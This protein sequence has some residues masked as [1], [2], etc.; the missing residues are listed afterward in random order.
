MPR[1]T[2]LSP[3]QARPTARALLT[4]I[5][6]RHGDAGPM[7]RSMA[8]SPALLQGYLD[9]SRAMKR[10]SLPRP[11]S[12]KISLAVQEW[13]GCALCLAAHTAA[14]RAHGLTESDIVLARQGTAGDVRDAALI[15]FAMQV[16]TEPAMVTDDDITALRAHGWSDRALADVVG[17]VALNQLTGAF[18]LV[19]GLEV[20]DHDAVH[21]AD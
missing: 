5:V 21:A 4:E 13:L 11:L 7:V 18:N 15:T 20:G 9:L 1:L 8:H 3:E 6:E 19:A 14:G 12:E 16:L 10:S 17:L 2:S